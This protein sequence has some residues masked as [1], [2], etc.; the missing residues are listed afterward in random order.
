MGDNIHMTTDCCV[1]A[2]FVYVHFTCSDPSTCISRQL[3]KLQVAFA[4]VQV[5]VFKKPSPVGTYKNVRERSDVCLFLLV[6]T[7]INVCLFFFRD[8]SS[9]AIGML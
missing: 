3:N 2:L 7:L 8:R 5:Y 4:E 9:Y 6:Y 1:L